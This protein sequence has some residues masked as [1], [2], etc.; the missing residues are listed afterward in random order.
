MVSQAY[1]RALL[2]TPFYA[3]WTIIGHRPSEMVGGK[4]IYDHPQIEAN[5]LPYGW[6]LKPPGPYHMGNLNGTPTTM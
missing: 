6:R 2:G 5:D 3:N 1:L 4:P